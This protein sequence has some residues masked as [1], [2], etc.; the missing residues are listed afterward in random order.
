MSSTHLRLLWER[1]VVVGRNHFLAAQNRNDGTIGM[2]MVRH[3]NF[4]TNIMSY[5]YS[6]GVQLVYLFGC[7]TPKLLSF[8]CWVLVWSS[9]PLLLPH[10]SE[11][12]SL[13]TGSQGWPTWNP[14]NWRPIEFLDDQTSGTSGTSNFICNQ[15]IRPSIPNPQRALRR[16][17]NLQAGS[18]GNQ[19]ISLWAYM[20]S[21]NLGSKR[22]SFWT[23]GFRKISC[24]ICSMVESPYF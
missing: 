5:L 14:K 20:R 1:S 23:L 18:V 15:C 7:E 22:S 24:K 2:V 21:H 8:N 9:E 13:E 19:Q 4:Q 3:S 12:L 16:L 10:L 17:F 6:P 11:F